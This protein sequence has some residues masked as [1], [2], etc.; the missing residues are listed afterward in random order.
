M[1]ETS[2]FADLFKYLERKEYPSGITKDQKRRLREKAAVFEIQNSELYHKG[3]KGRLGKV[4]VDDEE[5][6]ATSAT[7]CPLHRSSKRCAQHRSGTMPTA[8][9]CI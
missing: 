4:I 6:Q 5:K 2:E 8:T 1:S 3:Y 7:I 9:K